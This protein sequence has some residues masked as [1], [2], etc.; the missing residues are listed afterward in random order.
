MWEPSVFAV[1]AV[2]LVQ[3]MRMWD[4][5]VF[6]VH[7]VVDVVHKDGELLVFV[8]HAVVAV[9]HKDGTR[10]YCTCCISCCI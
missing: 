4:S 1:V 7:S 10:I 5:S 9:V 6:A 8:V 2:V 3:Y